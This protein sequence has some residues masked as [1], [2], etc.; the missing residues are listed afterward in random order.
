MK[1]ISKKEW[2]IMSRKAG[3]RLKNGCQ[4]GFLF[5]CQSGYSC[6]GRLPKNYKLCPHGK[7]IGKNLPFVIAGAVFICSCCKQAYGTLNDDSKNP[8]CVQCK[9]TK[10]DTK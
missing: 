5:A 10:E 6:D 3:C 8:L 7:E 1:K 2:L 9:K 4:S